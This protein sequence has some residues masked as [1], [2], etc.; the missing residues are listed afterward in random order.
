MELESTMTYISEKL[1]V[2]LENAELFVVLDLVQAPSVGEI[3][4]TG[5]VEGWKNARYVYPV[6]LYA[7]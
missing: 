3:T 5:F 1:K 6:S 7:G 4:R 2:N